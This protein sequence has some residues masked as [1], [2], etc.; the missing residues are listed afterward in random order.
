MNG[1]VSKEETAMM[2]IS[3][4]KTKKR[5]VQHPLEGKRSELNEKPVERV[6]EWNPW[7]LRAGISEDANQVRSR[8]GIYTDFT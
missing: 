1:F 7:L 4:G 3:F 5:T 2:T 6:P 8:I